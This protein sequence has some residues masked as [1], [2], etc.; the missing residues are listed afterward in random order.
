[1]SSNTSSEFKAQYGEDRILAR[2]FAQRTGGYFVEVGSYNG[3][4]YSNTYYLEK[5]LGWTGVLIEADPKLH[6]QGAKIRPKSVN[7]NCAAV[8]PGS[9]ETVTFEIVEGCKWVSSVS[10]SDNMLKRIEDIPINIRKVT[11]PARTL[12][13]ILQEAG[14][15]QG[16]DFLSIDVEGHEWP[17]L[18]GFDAA[19]WK[20]KVIILERNDHFPDRRIMQYMQS[21]G[22][23]WRR[24]TGCN[25]WFYAGEAAS[26]MYGAR[27]FGLFLL[28]K[29]LTFWQPVLNGPV[30]R[31]IKQALRKTGLLEGVRA[32]VKGDSKKPA[33]VAVTAPASAPAHHVDVD[34][35]DELA[36]T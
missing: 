15:P 6:E 23:G 34:E 9:S 20:P 18:Q 5:S 35:D 28:P 26:A 17:V 36:I 33:K 31:A 19:R 1:M 16:I 21:H 29:Y 11:V 14:A 3:E 32:M 22:Y 30:K 27:L 12:D 13:T 10:V 25:D 4:S 2:E 7:V 8:A 24:T